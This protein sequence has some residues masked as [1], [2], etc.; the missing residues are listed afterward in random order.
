MRRPQGFTLVETLVVLVI[1]VGLVALMATL[2]RSVGQAAKVLRTDNSGLMLQL[3]MRE[4]LLHGVGLAAPGNTPTGPQVALPWV[5][6]DDN[7]LYFLTWRS[8]DQGTGGKPVLAHYQC[9]RAQRALIYREQALPAW[10]VEP[11]PSLQRQVAD[12]RAQPA[13]K[14]IGGLDDCRFGYYDTVPLKGAGAE[15]VASWQAELPPKLIHLQLNQARE[16]H[17]WLNLRRLDV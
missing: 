6:G 13:S 14:M 7:E 11:F 10:W 4:Q 16:L 9:D 8:R 15:G 1:S 5:G 12:I 2:L 17:L 3:V